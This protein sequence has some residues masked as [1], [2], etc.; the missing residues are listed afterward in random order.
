MIRT[1]K[2][3]VGRNAYQ[4]SKVWKL[5]FH[6]FLNDEDLILRLCYFRSKKCTYY[7]QLE[8]K[9]RET[10]HCCGC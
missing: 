10:N 4:L 2:G 8:I 3:C 6:A 5:G 9:V 7:I 1:R